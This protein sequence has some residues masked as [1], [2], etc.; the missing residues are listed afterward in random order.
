[1]N[2]KMEVA[3]EL[4]RVNIDKTPGRTRTIARRI[5]GTA[6]KAYYKIAE[7]D[8]MTILQ[9]ALTDESITQEAREAIERLITRVDADFNSPSTDPVNDS[10][11]VVDFVKDLEDKRK[12]SA[13]Q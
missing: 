8:V 13:S 9:K 6:L 5:A 7:I 12:R 2:W 4:Q 11:V 1:M 3:E 10:L